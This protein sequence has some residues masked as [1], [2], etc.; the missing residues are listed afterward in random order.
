[1]Q[2][3]KPTH[4]CR[5]FIAI[6]LVS[7]SFVTSQNLETELAPLPPLEPE[8]AYYHPLESTQTY[9]IESEVLPARQLQIA[10]PGQADRTSGVRKPPTVVQITPPAKN[11]LTIPKLGDS[12]FEASLI[13][14]L[15]LNAADYFSTK[16]ALKYDGIYEANP[17]MKGI[18]KNDWA[19]AAVKIGSS[20]GTYYAFKGLYKKNKTLAWILNLGTNFA[21]SYVV[22]NN[23]K[24]L[25]QARSLH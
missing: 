20:I 6:F 23:M 2:K 24:V 1:M 12:L 4:L 15:A 16:Q 10:T 22:A 13:S 17:F 3:R 25:N 19:F 18:V 11:S 8:E 9:A 14:M 5:L 7:G 21:L